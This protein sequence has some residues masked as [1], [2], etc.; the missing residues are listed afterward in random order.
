MTE[1]NKALAASVRGPAEKVKGCLE[2]GK[3][4]PART[5]NGRERKFCSTG[6]RKIWNNRRMI[7]GAVAYDEI[8]KWRYDRHNAKDSLTTL[9]QIASMFRGKDKRAR[10]GRRSWIN[11]PERDTLTSASEVE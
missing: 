6:C 7:R 3:A 9:A 11:D 2:C 1:L 4:L 8:M 5:Y 10:N